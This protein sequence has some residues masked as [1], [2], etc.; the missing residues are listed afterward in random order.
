MMKVFIVI[1]I[2]AHVFRTSQAHFFFLVKKNEDYDVPCL[3]MI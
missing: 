3:R 2:P 1:V